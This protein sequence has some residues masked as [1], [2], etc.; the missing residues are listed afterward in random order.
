MVSLA[1]RLSLFHVKTLILATRNKHKTEEIQQILGTGFKCLSLNE[2]PDAPPVDETATTFGGNATLKSVGLA[3][4][5]L[6]TPSKLSGIAGEAYVLAD[7]SGLEVDALN[8]APGVYSARFAHLESGKP[9]NSPDGEN[10]AKLLSL[11]QGVPVEKR[12][13]RF[14]CALALTPLLK[15]DKCSSPPCEADELEVATLIFEGACE[16]RMDT[17]PAGGGGFGYD[18]MFIPAGYDKSFAELGEDVKN[19]LSHR[20]K[21]LAKLQQHFAKQS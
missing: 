14:R 16:G 2:F 13:A 20:S 7:D 6:E 5:L 21:A 12:N 4:W 3:R 11:M 9:G 8:G 10:N 19:R 17:K 18:P 1:F 15:A